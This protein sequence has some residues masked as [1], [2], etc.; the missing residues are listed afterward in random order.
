M[1]RILVIDDHEIVKAGISF[2][3]APLIP[4]LVTDWA[5]NNDSALEKIASNVYDLISIDVNISGTNSYGLV[6]KI[7]TAWPETK[8]LV[9]SIS[10]EAVYAKKYLMLGVKGYI[11]KNAPEKELAD[12]IRLVMQNRRYISAALNG[13]LIEDL[14]CNRAANPF[15][16]LSTREMEVFQRIIRGETQV[17]MQSSL[18]L[19]SSTINTYKA[20]IFKKL[21]CKTI[22]ELSTVAG[23]YDML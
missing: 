6:F 5:S 12:A 7:L 21:N 19:C 22:I 9:F 8:I 15:D 3:L 16:D 14:L 11:S 17:E 13:L 20:R 2:L 10:S 18:H 1:K 23:V 4:G